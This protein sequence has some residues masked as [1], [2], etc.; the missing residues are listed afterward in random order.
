MDLQQAGPVGEGVVTDHA[1]RAWALQRDTVYRS[2]AAGSLRR[3]IINSVEGDGTF[4]VREVGTGT[5]HDE[6]YIALDS[7]TGF[8]VDQYVIVGEIMGR[9]TEVGSTRVILGR[10]GAGSV[11]V[12]EDAKSQQDSSTA[13]TSSVTTFANAITLALALPAGT[14][15]VTAD[16]SV[17]LSHNVNRGNWR[18]EIDGNASTQH[19]LP[20]V[21]EER[22]A[23][24]HRRTGLAGNRTININLQFKSFD[25]GTISARNPLITVKAVRTA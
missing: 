4:Q 25:A 7:T 10:I 16:G 13:S 12:I 21:T 19:T 15:T 24:T 1:T 23:A 17:L 20:M 2:V 14:W 6:P 5:V 8:A 22:F 9:G 18:V 3:M 11:G